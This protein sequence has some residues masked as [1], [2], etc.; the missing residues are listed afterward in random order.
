M[1]RRYDVVAS[2][3]YEDRNGEAKKRWTRV[4]VAFENDNGISVK[5]DAAPVGREWDGWL[6]LFEPKERDE[7]P[8]QPKRSTDDFDDTPF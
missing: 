6:R 4:G 3:E 8:K 5:L 7:Q 2:Y 1:K